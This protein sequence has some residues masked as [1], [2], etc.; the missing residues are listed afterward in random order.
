[1]ATVY[2][3]T[4]FGTL[5]SCFQCGPFAGFAD[6]VGELIT[7]CSSSDVSVSVWK[8]VQT[9][10][11]FCTVSFSHSLLSQKWLSWLITG[12]FFQR[13]TVNWES[14]MFY[15]PHNISKSVWPVAYPFFWVFWE[16]A[17]KRNWFRIIFFS[18]FALMSLQIP[19]EALVIIFPLSNEYCATHHNSV[20]FSSKFLTSLGLSSL[21]V[22]SVFFFS[23]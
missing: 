16:S 9:P 15:C 7:Y 4:H 21:Q 2:A 12:A 14:N 19:L 22:H 23:E 1:M 8:P 17:G 10:C 18:D 3:L 11:Q 5:V 13:L 20:I 6:G